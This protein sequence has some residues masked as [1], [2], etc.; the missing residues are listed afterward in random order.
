MKSS[1]SSLE[2]P[3]RSMQWPYLGTA[4]LRQLGTQSSAASHRVHL[5]RVFLVINACTVLPVWSEAASDVGSPLLHCPQ[6]WGGHAHVL[7]HLLLLL[8]NH[9]AAELWKE[10]HSGV[11]QATA[12][13]TP[14]R[15]CRNK[16][17]GSIAHAPAKGKGHVRIALALSAVQVV[18]KHCSC[19]PHVQ[20]LSWLHCTCVAQLAAASLQL[21]AR[22][23]STETKSVMLK[24]GSVCSTSTSLSAFSPRS[25]WVGNHTQQSAV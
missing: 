20:A 3:L 2:N 8:K 4:I 21:R 25:Q 22:M 19:R 17:P 24:K 5:Q 16:R 23:H 6:L 11:D 13:Q 12:C 15:Q 9:G 10:I 18:C 14:R 1:S 7:L